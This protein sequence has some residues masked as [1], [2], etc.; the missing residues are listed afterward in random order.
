MQEGSYP[1]GQV[2]K[3]RKEFKGFANKKFICIDAIKEVPR[4]KFASERI[5]SPDNM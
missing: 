4:K 5:S 1:K 2:K 3:W